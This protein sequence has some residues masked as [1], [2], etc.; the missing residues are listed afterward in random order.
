MTNPHSSLIRKILI[1]LK[2][3]AVDK[4][5]FVLLFGS[6]P[7][8]DDAKL[9]GLESILSLCLFYSKKNIF[10]DFP[11]GSDAL[12]FELIEKFKHTL[13][14][15]WQ[16]IVSSSLKQIKELNQSPWV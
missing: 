14:P 12:A 3:D 15:N 5:K 7:P 1:D 8:P 10:L 16:E 6:N 9:Q 4:Q 2:F 13:G 11:S